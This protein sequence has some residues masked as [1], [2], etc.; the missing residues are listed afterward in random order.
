MVCKLSEHAGAGIEQFELGWVE[1]MLD[2]EAAILD[3]PEALPD[4]EPG[5]QGAFGAGETERLRGD[6]ELVA[7]LPIG[8]PCFGVREQRG[9]ERAHPG[10]L[11]ADVFQV[12]EF[13]EDEHVA[14][15]MMPGESPLRVHPC[16][17]RRVG[18]EPPGPVDALS[19]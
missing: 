9:R 18:H 4:A 19:D 14:D 8:D 10:T 17:Q 11:V 15:A 13:V 5:Q 2:Q 3:L 12:G 16:Q 6:S 1:L 7:L